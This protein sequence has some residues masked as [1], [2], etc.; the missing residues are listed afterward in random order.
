MAV[1]RHQRKTIMCTLAPD[2]IGAFILMLF[3]VFVSLQSPAAQSVSDQADELLHARIEA[4]G[5]PPRIVVGNELVYASIALPSFYER[6]AYRLAWSDD[7][8]PLSQLEALILAIKD[9]SR[10]GLTPADYHLAKIE[11][12]YKQVQQNQEN[13]FSF[14]PRILVDLD[15]LATDAFL[16]YGSH[17]LAG[18]VNPETIDP[19]WIANRRDADISRPCF[20]LLSIPTRSNRP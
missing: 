9:A 10:E 16:I 3:F 17:L 5:G 1:K 18:R 6:R 20:R 8:G 7:D 11:A 12:I 15:L 4:A 13:R 19:E 14:T 2:L